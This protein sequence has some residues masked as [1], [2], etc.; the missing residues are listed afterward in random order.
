MSDAP[1][2]VQ[3]RDLEFLGRSLTIPKA[4]GRIA[5]ISFAQLCGQSHSAADFLEISKAFDILILVDVPKM[6]LFQRNEARRFITLI[7]SLYERKVY[8]Y[9]HTHTQFE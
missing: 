9:A 3:S 1:C 8:I 6:T 2:L 5:Q 7:D 4:A